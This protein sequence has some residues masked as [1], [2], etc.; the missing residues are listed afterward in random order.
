MNNRKQDPI[1]PIL[2]GLS[3]ILAA[4]AAAHV[5]WTQTNLY[6]PDALAV[7]NLNDS[8]FNTGESLA[9]VAGYPSV[10]GLEIL[11]GTGTMSSST[12]TP[13]PFFGTSLRIE[14]PLRA[15]TFNEN[16]G[17]WDRD[18]LQPQDNP[19]A[20]AP[21]NN[22]LGPDLVTGDLTIEFWLKWDPAPS[23]SSVEVGFR[24]GSRL[25]ITRDTAT[26]ANDQFAVVATHGTIVS[27]PGF[28][29]WV[30]VGTE[31]APLDE[32]IHFAISID[33]TGNYYD[34]TPGITHHFYD[35]GSVARFYINGHAVG[36]APHT[37]AL[38][39]NPSST[40]N[41]Q[42]HG[43]YSKLTIN[44]ISGNVTIDDVAV[45]AADL[46]EAGTIANP[47]ANGRGNV[48]SSVEMWHV[49]E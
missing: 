23:A 2:L 17:Y 35:T 3:M 6:H 14:G 20:P 12:S 22:N 38:N 31:E 28:T 21:G 27:A 39:G 7:W 9:T 40:N 49:F 15:D 5:T 47:F 48:A 46:S 13:E 16:F 25:R 45:W 26:P 41:L 34:A 32:W 33:A 8:S 37:V 29:N 11:T 36:T 4:H 1:R 43:E 44:N 18:P 10:N 24:R 42:I 30:D 19:Q